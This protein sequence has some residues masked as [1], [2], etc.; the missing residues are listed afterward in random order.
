MVISRSQRYAYIEICRRGPWDMIRRSWTR[1]WVGPACGEQ[2]PR[3]LDEV[4]TPH[5]H[6][7]YLSWNIF[8]PVPGVLSFGRRAHQY[9]DS[10]ALL[11]CGNKSSDMCCCILRP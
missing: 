6:F 7:H 4:F 10:L 1:L 3:G 9:V 5:E 8:D 11:P 2:H